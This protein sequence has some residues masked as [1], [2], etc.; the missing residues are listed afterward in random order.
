MCTQGLPFLN[1]YDDLDVDL[2]CRLTSTTQ[3]RRRLRHFRIYAVCPHW[4]RTPF[5]ESKF[6]CFDLGPVVVLIFH[7]LKDNAV[8]LVPFHSS[9]ESLSSSTVKYPIGSVLVFSL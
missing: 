7:K 5:S 9:S 1:M 2:S 6:K 8:K 4:F 3:G